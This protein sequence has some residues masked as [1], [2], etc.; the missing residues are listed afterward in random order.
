MNN[1]L[2]EE[3]LDVVPTQHHCAERITQSPTSSSGTKQRPP[4]RLGFVLPIFAL[5]ALS[6]AVFS[7]WRLRPI[8]TPS[9]PPQAPPTANLGIEAAD[10]KKT[11]AGVGLVEANSENIALSVPVPGWVTAVFAH[12]GDKIETGEKLFSLDDRDLKVELE[13]RRAQL[14]QAQA[15]VESAKASLAD[16]ELLDREAQRLE[17]GAVLSNEE[18]ARKRIA[19]QKARADLGNAE[20]QV[21]V[22]ASQIKQ[23]QVNIERLT[24]TSPIDGTVLHSEVRLGQYAP[25]GVLETPLMVLGNIEPLHV[26]V[27]IDEN[28]AWRVPAGAPATAFVRGNGN[29]H[30]NLKF[31]RFEP[32]V[33]PKRSLTGDSTE[34][35]DTPVLQAI[36]RIEPSDLRLFVGQQMDVYINAQDLK[37]PALQ[38]AAR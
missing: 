10:L 19:L 28:D 18:V 31:V 5:L 27:D 32:S 35:V 1:Q 38:R 26:R 3:K 8:R 13:V 33:L 7:V 24:V 23:T 6:F 37:V 29:Q 12:A 22:I 4:K 17:K 30:V 21:A 34:R 2:T 25:T 15:G 20:A 14:A 11:V 16:S 9:S 36:Y